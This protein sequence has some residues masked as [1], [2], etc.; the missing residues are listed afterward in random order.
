[1]LI[2]Q[3]QLLITLPDNNNTET[4]YGVWRRYW[5]Q[6]VAILSLHAEPSR[7]DLSNWSTIKDAVY[8]QGLSK[9]MVG[10]SLPVAELILVTPNVLGHTGVLEKCSLSFRDFSANVFWERR[11]RHKTKQNAA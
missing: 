4:L 10:L 11:N 1:M 7:S 9:V 2:Q 3:S 6:L 5:L 8:A